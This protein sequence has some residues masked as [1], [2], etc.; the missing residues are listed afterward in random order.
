MTGKRSKPNHSP[1]YGRLLIFIGII[2]TSALVAWYVSDT[3][4]YSPPAAYM[5]MILISAAL[6]WSTEII[7]LFATSLLIIGTQIIL[8]SNPGGWAILEEGSLSIPYREFLNPLTDPIIFLFLGGFILAKM[9]VKA[10][11]DT[12]LSS[13]MLRVFGLSAKNTLMGIIVITTIFGMWI[14]NTA[15]TAMMITL[16]GT[17]LAFVPANNPFRRGLTLAI[18]FSAGIGGMM[19]P[20][21]SP[22]NA[23]AVGLLASEGI[24]VGFLEWMIIMLP[25][26][27]ILL[28]LLYHLIWFRYKPAEPL[29]LTPIEPKPFTPQ[30]R[31]VVVIFVLTV[32]MWLTDG[33]H[34]IPSA[35]VAL[36]PAIIFTATGL[37][38][39]KEFNKLEWNILFVIGG[40]LALGQGMSLTG[41]DEELTGLLPMESEW[42]VP[43]TLFVALLIGNFMSNTTTAIL[44]IP[45]GISMAQSLDNVN[46][47]FMAVGLAVMAG[48]SLSLPISTPP[49]TIVYA[50]RELKKKD[51]FING[52]IIGLCS[53]GLSYGYFWLL[54]YF[55][56][57]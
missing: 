42:I 44:F 21:G 13:I 30:G 14:S 31:F 7:P 3:M 16:N 43:I 6:L 26:V 38:N 17:L 35:V 32:L 37:L 33:L 22:P 19:T 54:T 27:S 20:I 45:L 25:L 36:F 47:K 40:G 1:K 50:T 2:S 10:G 52:T 9:A 48:S 57:W 4:A 39:A 18:P 23:I 12:R 24:Y 15:T 53:I 8:L 56:L 55:N 49:N 51:F 11:V 5:L 34:G 46:M 28:F 41:L 29:R